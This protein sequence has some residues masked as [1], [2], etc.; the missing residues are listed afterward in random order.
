MPMHDWTKVKAGI[1]HDFHSLWVMAIRHTLNNGVLPAGY[2]ALSEQRVAAVEADVLTLQSAGPEPPA[3][4]AE[5][6]VELLER[7]EKA[8]RPRGRRLLVRDGNHEVVAVIELVSPGNIKD[9]ENY[10]AFVGKAADV[11]ASGIHLLVID[12][13]RPPK[14]SPGGLHAAIWKKVAR[15][16][17]GQKPFTPPTKQPLLAVSYCASA[18]EVTAAVQ[19][20]AIGE[21]VPDVPLFLTAD[22]AYVTVPLESTYQAAWPDVP[23]VWRDVLEA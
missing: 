3:A 14:H 2:Y 15:L 23:K 16:R 10:A 7:A 5:P 18:A 19:T 13:F 8:R 12:P 22:E 4:G 17:K 11:L 21:P 20:F 1:Y 6:A 9:R